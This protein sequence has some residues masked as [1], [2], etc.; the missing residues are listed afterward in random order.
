MFRLDTRRKSVQDKSLGQVEDVPEYSWHLPVCHLSLRVPRYH[1]GLRDERCLHDFT[2]LPRSMA[3]SRRATLSL[4]L[5]SLYRASL[6][7]P[8]SSLPS[9]SP[10]YFLIYIHIMIV[11]DWLSSLAGFGE[12]A[13]GRKPVAKKH[14]ALR[15]GI[16]GAAK[17][18]CM[19]TYLS[20]LS[21]CDRSSRRGGNELD[22]T[23]ICRANGPT[24]LITLS[25][26]DPMPMYSSLQW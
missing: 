4:P 19:I 17:I 24:A 10:K 7:K 9:Y 6:I 8:A 11:V 3:T 22:L 12:W 26:H 1:G 15:F 23:C 14:D 16:L 21:P 5:S 25:P 18:A 2:K 20:H 13:A